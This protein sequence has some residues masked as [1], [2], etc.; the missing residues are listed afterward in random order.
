MT[1]R[2][3]SVKASSGSS[4]SESQHVSKPHEHAESGD[5]GAPIEVD[6][7]IIKRFSRKTKPGDPRDAFRFCDKI[8]TSNLNSDKLPITFDDKSKAEE[9]CKLTFAFSPEDEKRFKRKNRHWWQ[10]GAEYMRVEYEVRVNLGA[11]DVTFELCKSLNVRCRYV[12][13]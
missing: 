13:R 10:F 5:R 1:R 3:I 2:T 11:A 7:P 9:L 8:I 12:C 4:R 6:E